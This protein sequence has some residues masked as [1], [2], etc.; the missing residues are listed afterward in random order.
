MKDVKEVI[1]IL[2]PYPKYHLTETISKLESLYDKVTS[3]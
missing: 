1:T 2:E 3:R